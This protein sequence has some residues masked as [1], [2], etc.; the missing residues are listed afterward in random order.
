MGIGFQDIAD[1][2]VGVIDLKSGVAVHAVA[3]QRNAY[4]EVVLK[5]GTVCGDPVRLAHHYRSL[6][7]KQLYVADLDGIV[8]NKIQRDCLAELL[9]ELFAESSAQDSGWDHVLLD[10]GCRS[11]SETQPLASHLDACDPNARD[12]MEPS[13]RVSFIV[14]SESA[15]S[16]VAISAVSQAIGPRRTVAGLDYRAGT[17]VSCNESNEAAFLREIRSAGVT[18]AVVLD[19]CAVGT[20]RTDAAVAACQKIRML[21]SDITIYSGGGISSASDVQE[22]R[23]AGSDYCLVATWLHSMC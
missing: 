15:S 3:G 2:L 18:R 4:Q 9:G 17:F 16:P 23:Q 10:V 5:D 21:D 22:L 12:Q 8:G 20:R 19:V 13:R 6:G 7:V 1:Y 11:G 14:A